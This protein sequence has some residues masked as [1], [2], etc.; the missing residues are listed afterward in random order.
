MGYN[1][2]L[3]TDE[4]VEIRERLQSVAK[5]EGAKETHG[6]L[7]Q[8]KKKNNFLVVLPTA[9]MC[10]ASHIPELLSHF[11]CLKQFTYVRKGSLGTPGEHPPSKSPCDSSWASHFTSAQGEVIPKV[12]SNSD[13]L[14]SGHL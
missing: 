7:F 8:M 11:L 1:V 13:I 9:D 10:F 4:A 12:P 3:G 2:R 14:I 6:E 5:P